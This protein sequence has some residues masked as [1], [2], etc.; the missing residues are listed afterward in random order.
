VALHLGPARGPGCHLQLAQHRV[1]EVDAVGEGLEPDGVLG[2]T[3]DRQRPGDRPERHDEVAVGDLVGAR[4]GADAHRPLLQV[5]AL[6]LADEELGMRAH[7]PQRDD[8]MA[9]LERAGRRL[10]Q[11]GRVEHEVVRADDG[12][13]GLA[14]AAGHHAAREASAEHEHATLRG[15]HP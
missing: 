8:D 1:A 2:Q 14:Q 13:P 4:V 5:G 10:G 3:G 6:D 9:R 11:H 15:P 7:G 12:R